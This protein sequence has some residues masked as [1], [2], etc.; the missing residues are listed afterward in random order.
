MTRTRLLQFGGLLLVPLSLLMA[1]RAAP[2]DARAGPSSETLARI[3]RDR[4][5]RVAYIDYPP[6][7]F[8]DTTSGDVRGHF[9]DALKEIVR[10]LDPQVRIEFE[11]TTWSDFSAALNTKRVDLSIAGTFA[12][13][14]RA[15]AVAF[16]RPLTYLGRSAIIRRGDVR[17]SAT[18]GPLQFDRTGVKVGVVDGEGSHEFVKAYFKHLEDIQVFSG[19][20]LSQ[21]LA[22]VSSGQVDVGLSDA[23]ET[24]KYAARHPETVDLFGSQ[25][26]DLTPIAWAVRHDDIVWKDFLNT[27]IDT[28]ETQGRLAMFERAYDYRWMQP[29][30]QFRPR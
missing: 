14:P 6:S 11:E 7:A 24:A 16:T 17:F 25:P 26:Y 28:L 12:T 30:R 9:V 10:Q 19:S 2:G 18:A 13:I 27:A 22:A 3:M 15:K 29:V 8:R 23:L 20:D 4:L 21:C 5:L 1:C